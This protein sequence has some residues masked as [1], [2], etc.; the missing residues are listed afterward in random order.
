M[1]YICILY[2]VRSF[3]SDPF[4]L[5]CACSCNCENNCILIKRRSFLVD[6][7]MAKNTEQHFY[8][9][10]THRLSSC[11]PPSVFLCHADTI[12]PYEWVI[13][14][15]TKSLSSGRE[16]DTR[17]LLL[18]KGC[19]FSDIWSRTAH[20]ALNAEVKPVTPPYAH[21]THTHTH[22]NLTADP[23]PPCGYWSTSQQLQIRSGSEFAL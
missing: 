4:A 17:L 20:M 6:R 23:W 2:N 15:E 18:L 11:F 19:I 12:S 14:S 7:K 3:P 1:I 10:S 8:F 13:Q 16:I 21:L 22:T 5:L 9:T